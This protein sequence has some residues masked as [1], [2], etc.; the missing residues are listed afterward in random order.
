M[1]EHRD[2]EASPRATRP[3]LPG[4][5]IAGENEGDGL[6]PWSWAVD[7]LT[8]ARNYFLATV[9]ATETMV[10]PHVMVVWGIW[11]D[12]AYLF[13]TDPASRKGKN[14]AANPRCVVTVEGG[15]EAVI[16]EGM[17][18][19]TSDE[20]TLERFKKAYQAKYALDMSAHTQPVYVVRPSMVFG[21]I[22]ETFTRSAT[23]WRFET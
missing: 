8:K 12:G 7:R 23:R 5:G 22:E 21:Q 15:E 17:A 2:L 11:Q 10:R 9:T 19:T 6:L 14:L 20:S 18:T 1:A 13:S 16:L 4:Y 3:N